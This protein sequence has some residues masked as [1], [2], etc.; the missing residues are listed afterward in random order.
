M[1]CTYEQYEEVLAPSHFYRAGIPPVPAAMLTAVPLA[2]A[3]SPVW[4]TRWPAHCLLGFVASIGIWTSLLRRWTLSH[5]SKEAGRRLRTLKERNAFIAEHR[6][7]K[8]LAFYDSEAAVALEGLDI[9]LTNAEKELSECRAGKQGLPRWFGAVMMALLGAALTI[10]SKASWHTAIAILSLGAAALVFS[11]FLLATLVLDE[12]FDS[13]GNRLAG[14]V[15]L[16]RLGKRR[17][18]HQAL[19]VKRPIA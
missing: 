11:I 9:D 14:Y 8:Q 12:L 4:W 1:S 10:L 16:L 13:H 15:R 2:F 19:K 17:L 3:L 18:S 7:D 6:V 5:W